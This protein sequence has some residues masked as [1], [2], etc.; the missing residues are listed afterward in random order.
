MASTIDR[1]ATPRAAASDAQ[2]IA[3]SIDAP[4]CFGEL[5]DRHVDAIFRYVAARVGA[6]AA[7]DVVSDTFEVAFD[8]RSRF[9]QRATSA[10]PWLYGIATNRLRKHRDAERTWLERASRAA[11][12]D[13]D[14]LDAAQADARVDAQRLAP[15]LAR[16]LLTLS[17][18][19]RDVLLLH[20]LEGLGSD[21]IAAVLGIRAGA[22]RT[23]LSRG[24]TR[25]RA[26]LE[27][28]PGPAATTA[29]NT[30][31]TREEADHA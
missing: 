19:E 2:L 31:T 12:A 28:C 13:R 15:R 5:F 27:E 21:E 18:A 3:R 17:T 20:A 24:T 9:D 29:T 8:R 30:A 25:L 1:S 10:R 16:A 22:A 6:S 4:A 11:V 7:E 23:R 14:E 26:V